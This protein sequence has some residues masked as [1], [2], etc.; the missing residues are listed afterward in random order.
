MVGLE[1]MGLVALTTALTA[2]WVYLFHRLGEAHAAR[3]GP[4]VFLVKPAYW[5]ALGCPAFFLGIFTSGVTLYGLQRILLGRRYHEYV[6]WDM[7]RRNM[8]DL[9]PMRG[10]IGCMVLLGGFVGIVSAA[11]AF[12]LMGCHVRFTDDEIV[13]RSLFALTATSHL[14]SAVDQVVFHTHK[15]R[16]RYYDDIVEGEGLYIH[17]TDDHSIVFDQ[18]FQLSQSPAERA[19]F[20]QFLAEKTGRPIT[21]VRLL[22]DAGR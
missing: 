7:G 9:E 10:V 12:F 21:K 6:Q 1:L 8:T 13:D 16:N 15:S 2:G 20:F 4:A 17:F 19:R 14:Y 18:V 11:F 5:A 3:F 22:R